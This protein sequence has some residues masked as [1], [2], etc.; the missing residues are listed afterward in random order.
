MIKILHIYRKW[1]RQYFHYYIL[2]IITII[3][4]EDY[5]G[6]LLIGII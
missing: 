3:I 5:F 2:Y 4:I 6:V 1:T